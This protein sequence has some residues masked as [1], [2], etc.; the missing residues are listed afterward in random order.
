M[1]KQE[2]WFYLILDNND[3]FGKRDKLILS[4]G[5]KLK[6]LESPHK[7][8][9][10]ILLQWVTFGWYKVPYQYKVKLL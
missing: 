4:N 9:Y 5:T 6:V 2:T 3:I 1:N 8:W 10:K 7:K